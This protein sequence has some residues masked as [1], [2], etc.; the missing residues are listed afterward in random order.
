MVDE[1]EF[2]DSLKQH[3]IEK[4]ASEEFKEMPE[5]GERGFNSSYSAISSNGKC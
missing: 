5:G 2:E 3:K 1:G 4:D